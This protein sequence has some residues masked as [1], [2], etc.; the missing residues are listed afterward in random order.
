MRKSLR[1]PTSR[2][3][4]VLRLA[5]AGPSGPRLR[6][7]PPCSMAPWTVPSQEQTVRGTPAACP[8][9]RHGRANRQSRDPPHSMSPRKVLSRERTAPRVS[10]ACHPGSEMRPQKDADVIATLW[11]TRVL[12]SLS[13]NWYCGPVTSRAP[14]VL[15]KIIFK[16]ERFSWSSRCKNLVFLLSQACE[17]V[18]LFSYIV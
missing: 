4:T 7:A 14:F 11:Y 13:L 12:V 8:L 5:K 1:K 17:I 15:A 18:Y 9:G 6:T 2:E 16:A 3:R 10:E